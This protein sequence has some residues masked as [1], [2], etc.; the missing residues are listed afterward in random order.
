MHIMHT[1]YPGTEY[2]SVSTLDYD[3]LISLLYTDT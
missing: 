2:V 1:L 3:S